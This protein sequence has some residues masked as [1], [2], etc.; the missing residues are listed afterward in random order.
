MKIITKKKCP[1]LGNCH[2]VGKDDDKN[3]MDS[4]SKPMK[5]LANPPKILFAI[6]RKQCI[7]KNTI[8]QI[9]LDNN[10]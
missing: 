2:K 7:K 8:K 3:K 10:K 1:Y 9:H 4:I 5:I 6:Y